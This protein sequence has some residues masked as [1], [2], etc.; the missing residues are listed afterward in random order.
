MLILAVFSCAV[1]VCIRLFASHFVSGDAIPQ[2]AQIIS[3]VWILFLVLAVIFRMAN[4][5]YH[6]FMERKHI[7]MHSA[8][9]ILLL[10]G[11]IILSSD[12]LKLAYTI[13]G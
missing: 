10:L 1:L 8:L 6:H 7:Q 13:T 4:A 2:F 12:L 3:R 11:L 9:K 5:L